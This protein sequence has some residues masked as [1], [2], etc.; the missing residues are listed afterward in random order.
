[1]G[2]LIDIE[3]AFLHV[4][5]EEAIYMNL[6]EGLNKIQGGGK[7]NSTDCIILKKCVYGLYKLHANGTRSLRKYCKN[8]ISLPTYWIH[9][10]CPG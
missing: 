7:N 8:Y 2:E 3:T 9:V 10:V 5:M 1:M 6:P 4:D